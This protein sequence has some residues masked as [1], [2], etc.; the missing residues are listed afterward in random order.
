PH[1]VARFTASGDPVPS[2][3]A[4]I[5]RRKLSKT[6]H[7]QSRARRRTWPI[8]NPDAKNVPRQ[9]LVP[10]QG[11]KVG[12]PRRQDGL[13]RQLPLRPKTLRPTGSAGASLQLAPQSIL[14]KKQRKNGNAE[15]EQI[16]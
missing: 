9:P 8:N 14:R 3:R 1:T 16:N 12:R 11:A 4:S 5:S 6:G 2:P 7:V 10:R 13:G 15:H